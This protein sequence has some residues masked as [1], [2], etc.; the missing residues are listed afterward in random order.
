M[1]DKSQRTEPPTQRRIEKARKEGNFPVSR[2]FVSSL[3]F[4]A[5]VALAAAF[6]AEAVGGLGRLTRSLLRLGFEQEVTLEAVEHVFTK[7]LAPAA[8]PLLAAGAGLMALSLGV[9]LLTT[10]MGFALRKLRPDFSRLDP[11][12]RLRNLPRQNVPQFFQ[13]AVLLPLFL[14]VVYAIVAGDLPAFLALPLMDAHAALAEVGRILQELLWKAAAAFLVL[15]AIDLARQRRRYREDLKMTKQEV[16]DELKEVEGDPRTKARIRRLQRALLE[17]RMMDGVARSTAV[18]VNPTHY[19]VAIRYEPA[20]MAAPRVLAKGKNYLARRIREK[21]LEHE[22]PIVEN[23]PL[24]RALY[25]AVEVGQEIP[26]HLYRAVAEILA[27]IYR[28]M[29]ARMP[30][31]QRPG[32]GR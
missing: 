19:A 21:A 1:P 3:Q 29:G 31:A 18:I 5:F 14:A 26:V 11:A 27:Y 15:G 32:T 30:G 10:R 17:R 8:L 4:A 9:Q 12:K 20:S 24:A 7:L 2:D 28:V 6:G 16:R 23:P 25:E 22:I 13:A